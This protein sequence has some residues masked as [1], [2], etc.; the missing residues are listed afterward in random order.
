MKDALELVLEAY[1]ERV[2][3]P[4]RG[5]MSALARELG[6]KNPTTVQGWKDRG[7]VPAE[8]VRAVIAAAAKK[9][10]VLTPDDFLPDAP[11]NS[12]E[13]RLAS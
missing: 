13:S 1:G 9:N 12:T 10:I 7:R 6:H 5:G 8:H 3:L 11:R 4:P 2:G